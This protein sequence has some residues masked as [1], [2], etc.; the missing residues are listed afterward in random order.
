MK[1]NSKYFD[2]IRVGQKRSTSDESRRH[3]G[4]EWKGCDKP[5]AHRAPKGRGRDGEYFY[6]CV[7]HVRQYNATYNYF[8]GMSDN[9]VNDFR[10]DALTGHRPTWKVGANAWAHGTREGGSGPEKP[11]EGG[12][13]ADPNN[14]AAWRAKKVR[15]EA[16]EQRRKL[17]PLEK[18]S[19]DALHLAEGA[20]K[21]EIKARF[22]ELVKRH[23]PDANGG[24][25]RSEDTLRE[26]IQ[27]YNYLKQ[28]G[29][30]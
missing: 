25:T 15:E 29:L 12:V 17:K 30:V 16:P 6:F 11:N 28:A 4:C 22:K 8:D 20:T 10:K 23:H 7:D 19:L 2:S 27:A 1:L 9:E 24:D 13:K 26:I 14:F 3:P 21:E 5:G 18:K